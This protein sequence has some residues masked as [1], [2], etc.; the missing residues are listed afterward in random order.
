MHVNDV[1]AVDLLG[2]LLQRLDQDVVVEVV[3]GALVDEDAHE[4]VEGN[5]VV[6]ARALHRE[7]VVDRA[8]FVLHLLDFEVRRLVAECAEDV[9]HF[10]HRD[11]VGQDAR[12]LGLLAVDVFVLLGAVLVAL[13]LGRVA[14]LRVVEL[15]LHVLVQV[16]VA[17][18][19]DQFLFLGEFQEAVGEFELALDG[20]LVELPDLD[21]EVLAARSE[22]EALRRLDA[23]VAQRRG[24]RDD[25]DVLVRVAVDGLADQPQDAV[26]GRE[27]LELVLLAVLV[28]VPHGLEAAFLDLAEVGALVGVL[29]AVLDEREEFDLVVG[30]GDREEV[31]LH[32]RL[33]GDALGD[34]VPLDADLLGDDGV[35][36]LEAR[37]VAL[38]VVLYDV[39]IG[40]DREE[41]LLLVLLLGVDLGEAEVGQ[42]LG[43]LV[44]LGD[45]FELRAVLRVVADDRVR[46][47]NDVLDA[48]LA[49]VLHGE[50]T[51]RGVVAD[52]EELVVGRELDLADA[53]VFDE[54]V[55]E[56]VALA[57]V[58]LR[59]H[60]VVVRQRVERAVFPRDDDVLAVRR[61]LDGRGFVREVLVLFDFAALVVPELDFA[62]ALVAALAGD[63]E[64]GETGV[65]AHVHDFLFESVEDRLLDVGVARDVCEHRL[66]VGLHEA[67][68][69]R[70]YEV[71]AHEVARV[72]L[73][74]VVRRSE[75]R[76]GRETDRGDFALALEVGGHLE[77]ALDAQLGVVEADAPVVDADHDVL[78]DDGHDVDGRRAKLAAG[79]GLAAA[80]ALLALVRRQVDDLE[81]RAAVL[82]ALQVRELVFVPDDHAPFVGARDRAVGFVL[83]QRVFLFARLRA[84][85]DEARHRNLFVR[86]LLLVRARD[87]LCVHVDAGVFIVLEFPVPEDDELLVVGD[88]LVRVVLVELDLE[89]VLEL[90]VLDGV[91]DQ[92][93]VVALEVVDLERMVRLG[94]EQRDE[95]AVVGDVDGGV[96]VGREVG[97]GADGVARARVPLDDHGV[98]AAVGRD[99]ERLVLRHGRAGD[100]VHVALQLQVALGHP[101]IDDPR[102]ARR[103]EELTRLFTRQVVHALHEIFVKSNYFL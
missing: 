69:L 3:V 7:R 77:V 52:R 65:H 42:D 70:H 13:A 1:L 38:D 46:V 103:L 79:L 74:G 20:V 87:R 96:P 48:V 8:D 95:A 28:R 101:I 97:E 100:D 34:E 27:D 63:G 94:G 2:Q 33:A 37:L 62:A 31:L 4:H 68:L 90:L 32:L 49:A 15:V 16:H 21:R 54:L 83:P 89:L 51:E 73:P 66:V 44:R 82:V 5:L 85:R 88:Q 10:V 41:R 91:L 92:R 9:R 14:Q 60:V 64:F 75:V 93:E 43:L 53:R 59:E 84:H 35:G 78:V 30:G 86:R 39:A 26:R 40:A 80:R 57:V 102:V 17:D 71:G 29:E 12:L 58:E 47:R 24:V 25:P 45:G 36:V 81:H 72:V 99:D 11:R 76:R 18:H 22:D 6:L 50:Q 56:H 23:E 61:L 98:L 55:L 67:A 19:L